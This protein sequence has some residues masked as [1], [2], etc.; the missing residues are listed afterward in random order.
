MDSVVTSI[1]AVVVVTVLLLFVLAVVHSPVNTRTSIATNSSKLTHFYSNYTYFEGNSAHQFFV[2][3][4]VGTFNS[5]LKGMV[6][7]PPRFFN[8]SLY[9]TTSGPNPSASNGS[10]YGQVYRI[11]ASNGK[12]VWNASFE[13]QIM[14]QPVV[15]GNRVIVGIGNNDF[16]IN[17]TGAYVMGTIENAVVALN[18]SNG[19]VDWIYNDSGEDMPTPAYFNGS[20]IFADGSGRVIALNS[21]TGMVE[22]IDNVHGYDSMSSPLLYKGNIYFGMLASARVY[23]ISASDG[24]INWEDNFS[25]LGNIG[26]ISDCSPIV[27]NNSLITIYTAPVDNHTAIMPVIISLN[28]T[29]GYLQWVTNESAGPIPN[30]IEAPPISEY[31]GYVYSG[32]PESGNFFIVNSTTGSIYKIIRSAP[33][34]GTAFSY[35]NRTFVPEYDGTVI[36]LNSTFGESTYNSGDAMLFGTVPTRSSLI[37][38]G[39]GFLDSLSYNDI[40]N[41]P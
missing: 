21:S 6:I 10:T 39:N 3:A 23:S 9:V 32:N 7:V 11:N 37:L 20:V 29:N 33:V 25:S 28:A 38:Y 4:E 15:A 19:N 41:A 24:K 8:G 27:Y 12:V 17:S 36:I 13:N 18:I 1:S 16:Y 22:W 5:S 30:N 26:G 34:Y 31:G 14:T 35:D 2:N 40:F